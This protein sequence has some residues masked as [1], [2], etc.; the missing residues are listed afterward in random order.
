MKLSD[1]FTMSQI[2]KDADI[3]LT[4]YSI[5]IFAGT[6]TFAETEYF[7][8]QALDN[9]NVSAVITKHGLLN[10]IT[11]DKGLVASKS[12]KKDFFSLHNFMLEQGC[13]DLVASS[14]IS[15]EAVISSTAVIKPNVIIES[16]VIIEDYAIIESNSVLKKGS[17]VGAHAVIGAR[18]MHN[19]FIDGE[20]V[21]VHDAGGVVLDEDVQVLS[22]ATIQ[23]SYF[24]EFTK[25]G[26][27]SIVSVQC[28]VGHGCQV[29]AHTMIAGNAQ[30]AGYVYVGNHVWIG[31]SV[32]VAHGLKIED[33]AEVL[34]GSVVISNVKK[35]QKVSG[36]FAMN[37]TRNIR[38]FT[39]ESR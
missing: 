14:Q 38:K 31:P 10:T 9:P 8:K 30:L 23:K 26:F 19:T 17:F 1:F 3:C 35:S 28:N 27:N 37:H 25:I 39:R 29:G 2:K 15:S 36:N 5:S 34:I 12:P 13:F 7:L 20:C 11:T 21:W 33:H 22:H 24:C 6:V 16:G 32:T 4:H 18:G